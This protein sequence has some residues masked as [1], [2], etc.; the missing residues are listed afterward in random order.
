MDIIKKEEVIGEGY[1]ITNECLPKIF[2]NRDADESYQNPG[3]KM[4]VEECSD[5][6]SLIKVFKECHCDDVPDNW[7]DILFNKLP[8]WKLC[9]VTVNSLHIIFDFVNPELDN[10][11]VELRKAGKED[12]LI[13]MPEPSGFA[14]LAINN[15]PH[16]FRM[17]LRFETILPT[18][19]ASSTIVNI[20]DGKHSVIKFLPFGYRSYEFIGKGSFQNDYGAKVILTEYLW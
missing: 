12:V 10:Q 17:R 8:G 3:I 14:M 18:G 1:V 15:F 5:M 4:I 19:V 2:R 16:R 11:R 6:D 20:E 7:Y 13:S 9:T